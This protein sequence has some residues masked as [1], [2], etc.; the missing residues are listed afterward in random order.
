MNVKIE[1]DYRERPSGILEV[2]RN[3]SEVV[4]EEKKLSIGDYRINGHIAVER[5]STKDFVISIIDGRLFSQASRLKKFTQRPI[6]IIEGRDLY[7][8]GYAMD[9]QAIKGAITSLSTAWYIPVVFSKDVN[10]T[11]DFLVMTG[12]QDVEYQAQYVKRV[13]RKPKRVKRLKLHILQGLPQI[14]PKT[15]NRMLEY[16]GSIEKAITADEGELAIV[17][18]IG[19][20]KAAMI[21]EIVR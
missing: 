2:L 12:I 3:R 4:V 1:V 15:A 10:G 17:E 16:F 13:G 5:K 20:K 6:I 19:R 9:P 18:G 11:A 7:H 8:T 14:G 21:R